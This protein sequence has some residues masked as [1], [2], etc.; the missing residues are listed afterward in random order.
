[1]VYPRLLARALF[2][3]RYLPVSEISVRNPATT[4][5]VYSL[6]NGGGGPPGRGRPGKLMC[7]IV[8]YSVKP[9]KAAAAGRFARESRHGA[10]W[11]EEAAS[12]ATP[13]DGAGDPEPQDAVAARR[14]A[15]SA[16]TGTA[17]A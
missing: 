13:P 4:P 6:C 5:H 1:M 17:P 14:T 3:S 7:G 8:Q 2:S 16:A 12:R 9:G 15:H 10:F 11:P